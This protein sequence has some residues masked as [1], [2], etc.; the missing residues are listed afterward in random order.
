MV[1]QKPPRNDSF[2]KG[3]E[4]FAQ[5]DALMSCSAIVVGG[6]E[7]ARWL[8]KSVRNTS[9]TQG[10]SGR[11]CQA[12]WK[13]AQRNPSVIAQIFAEKLRL[14]FIYGLSLEGNI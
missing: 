13:K 6:G 10:I 4:I 8:K 9:L 11:S 2:M 3:S 14:E 12:G 1:D 7:E 5:N